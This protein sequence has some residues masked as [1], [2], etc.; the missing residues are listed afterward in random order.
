M[1]AS[2]RTGSILNVMEDP[3]SVDEVRKLVKQARMTTLLSGLTAL[4]VSARAEMRPQGRTWQEDIIGRSR[5]L[6][7]FMCLWTFESPSRVNTKLWDA[8]FFSGEIPTIKKM[9]AT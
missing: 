9:T 1:R 6:I 7:G 8:I 3:A 4:R 2:R 5:Q